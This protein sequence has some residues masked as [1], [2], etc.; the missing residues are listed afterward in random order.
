LRSPKTPE[1]LDYAGMEM[2]VMR[3]VPAMAGSS[4][5]E[6]VGFWGPKGC[7]M[8]LGAR[9]HLKGTMWVLR[10]MGHLMPL[11][12]LGGNTR[13]SRQMAASGRG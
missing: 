9:W 7:V 3:E 4:K 8:G 2:R 6:I 12:P 11:G 13:V 1:R 5:G 10:V